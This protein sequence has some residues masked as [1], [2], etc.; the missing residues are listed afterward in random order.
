MVDARRCI[1]YHTIENR[2]FIPRELRSGFGTRVYGCDVC[3]EVCPWNRFAQEAK[4]VLLERRFDLAEL[5]LLD[6]LCLTPERFREVFRG[7]A[8]KRTKLT[9][10]LRNACIAAGNVWRNEEAG[11][12]EQGAG[13]QALSAGLFAP[14]HDR[15]AG[16]AEITRLAT[17]ESPVVRGHAVWALR[18]IL[19]ADSP[20]F[21][22]C[23]GLARGA[24]QDV[25]V[26]A[27]YAGVTPP[28]AS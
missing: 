12:G 13:R 20:E 3:A 1:S 6:L 22:E 15:A 7:T 28:P 11:S 2:G 27:E 4:A 23:L 25:A 18:E 10:L 16:V 21:A 24:E 8:I 26:L 9:G 14:L 17:H 5:T 19:G